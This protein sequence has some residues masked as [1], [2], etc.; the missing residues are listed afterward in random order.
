MVNIF[1]Q[2]LLLCMHA[3]ETMIMII[4]MILIMS[5]IL[6]MNCPFRPSFPCQRSIHPPSSANGGYGRIRLFHC[7][8]TEEFSLS[9]F[10]PLTTYLPMYKQTDS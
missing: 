6:I 1:L 3:E 4:I 2:T 10:T 7:F 8:K 9:I 5:M